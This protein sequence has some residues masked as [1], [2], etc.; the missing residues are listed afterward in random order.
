MHV[1]VDEMPQTPEE[2]LF[3]RPHPVPKFHERYRVCSLWR[4]DTIQL[5][6]HTQECPYLITI[7]TAG[8][9]KN[10]TEYQWVKTTDHL[11]STSGVYEIYEPVWGSTTLFYDAERKQF[12]WHTYYNAFEPFTYPI[13]HWRKKLPNPRK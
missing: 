11:P 6:Q 3:S 10:Q 7:S 13:T 5:C 12:G 2:C 9:I 4:N 1:V 8:A